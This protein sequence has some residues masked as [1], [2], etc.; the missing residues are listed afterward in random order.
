MSESEK[1][2]TRLRPEMSDNSFF[3]EKAIIADGAEIARLE[4]E[5][6][7]EPWSENAV[8]N[9]ITAENSVFLVCRNENR[10][11]GYVSGRDNC[12]EFYINNIA[13]S[14]EYR[15][16]GIG[17]LLMDSLILNAKKR[18]CEFVTLEVRSSNT[19][20]RLLYEKCGLTEVGKRR[21]F[22]RDPTED[23]VLYTIF[24]DSSEK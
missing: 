16:N 24:F 13:V 10:V 14:E 6:F 23:A 2:G 1:R 12:G 11:I 19:A 5:Y 15:K 8:I 9:E 7:S 17:R 21:D 3:V 4:R 20:A 22:Y 18:L